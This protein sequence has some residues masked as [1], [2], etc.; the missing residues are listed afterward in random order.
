MSKS[1]RNIRELICRNKTEFLPQTQIF[2]PDIFD[3]V[4]FQTMNYVRSIRNIKGLDHPVAKI[5][6]LKNLRT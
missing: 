1:K 2:N 5:K 4:D 3:I 6:G